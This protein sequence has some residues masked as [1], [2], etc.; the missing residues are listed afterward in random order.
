MLPSASGS[1]APKDGSTGSPF[2]YQRREPEKTLLHRIVRENLA[3]FLAEA[4]DRYPSGDLPAFVSQEFE[5]Y[6]RCGILRHGFARV[7]CPSCRDE[8]LV[9]FSC[10]NRGVCPSCCARRMADS[11][12]HLRDSV[13][14]SVPVRQW[15]FTLPKRLRFL[16][17]WRPKLIS[18]MLRLFLR[19][20]FSWQRRCAR[21]Q[22]IRSPL[23]GAVSFI[24]RFG[25]S[26]NLNIHVHAILPD[27]V[28]F[29]DEDGRVQFHP[30]SAP[31]YSDLEK[32][33]RKLVPRLLRKLGEEELPEQAQ[34]LLSLCEAFA[35]GSPAQATD[36]PRGLGVFCEGFSLHAGVFVSDLDGDALERLARYCARPPLSLR[37]LE[38]Q[39]D[40]QILYHAKHAAPGAPRLLRLSPTQ[41]MGRLAALIPPP[42]AHL[43]RFH[44]IFAPHSK[45]R[46]RIIPE[47][48]PA[49]A[50]APEPPIV[51]PDLPIAAPDLPIATPDL[52]IATPDLSIA[53]QQQAPSAASATAGVD[54]PPPPSRGPYRLPWATLL[55]RVF[56]LQVLTCDRC[57]GKRR[58]VALI[59]KDAAIKKI[60]THLGLPTQPPA[61]W[62]AR[63]PPRAADG[64]DRWPQDGIDPIPGDWYD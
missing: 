24:Q 15:V 23:C 20:L 40:G 18:L 12:A 36:P 54:P 9:A 10:K 28:F 57:G 17:A 32:L 35:A 46:S 27:G 25:S 31:R 59:D 56:A 34:W 37:R 55:R 14:P 16:L 48:S 42:R 2:R 62:P 63:A 39:E 49:A 21:R 30:L 1:P 33:I 13:F 43:T 51:T 11:A 60:L 4:A 58:L 6:L 45:H 41:F 29:E 44:G 61:A 38:L 52:P 22:G 50:A 8:I 53:T 47:P 7:R 19:A 26:L 64:V 3:T 5:R